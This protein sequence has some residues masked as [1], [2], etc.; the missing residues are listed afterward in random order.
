MRRFRLCGRCSTLAPAPICT[1][2]KCRNYARTTRYRWLDHDSVVKCLLTVAR[3][4]RSSSGN[5][6]SRTPSLTNH[7]GWWLQL[8]PFLSDLT[9]LVYQCSGINHIAGLSQSFNCQGSAVP[10]SHRP[11]YVYHGLCIWPLRCVSLCRSRPRLAAGTVSG[12]VT[13]P[14]CGGRASGMGQV[15][16]PP[17]TPGLTSVAY[18]LPA[19]CHPG[20]AAHPLFLLSEIGH[21]C[22]HRSIRP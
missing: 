18:R 13:L 14:A 21:D 16:I 5:Y 4:G 2:L 8:S 1:T 22:D 19:A 3:L 20:H 9:I 10:V 17:A 7:I 15:S 12:A 6:G 11:G